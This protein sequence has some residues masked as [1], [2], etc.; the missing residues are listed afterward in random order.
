MFGTSAKYL[1]LAE[2]EGLA[3]GAHATTS[4]PCARSSRPAARSRRTAT[5]TS[6]ATIKRDVH[7]ASISGGTD[8]VSCFALGNP[9]GPVWRG[10]LQMR[11]LGMAVDVFDADGRPVARSRG[12]AGLH[13]A[14][15]QHAGRVLGRSRRR[16]VPGRLLRR[17]IPGVWRHGDWARLTEHDGLVI[18]GR[19]D[20]TLNPGGVRIGTAE[21]Y[22]Q[23]EQ[24]PEVVESLVVGQEWD[25]DVRIVLFVRLREGAALDD[26]PAGADPA[27][28]PG[29]REPSPRT[30]QDPA[31]GG[32]PAHDQRQD[33]RAG[34][35][36]RDPR[37]ARRRT[38]T[39]WPIPGRWTCTGI[40]RRSGPDRDPEKCDL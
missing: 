16:E 3:P 7:L 36:R 13:A 18:L 17:T 5:T 4:R 34:R 21:I 15:S 8:I 2:K 29:A 1:A 40:W 38:W 22:R 35:A 32:H 30:A 23:V 12:R 25:G 33:H 20:A 24:L 11:G 31:G 39:R 19:S 27:P 26:A 6:T 37:T 10:E 28:D 14:L 9:I